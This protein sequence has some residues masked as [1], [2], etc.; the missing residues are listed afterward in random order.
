MP[1]QSDEILVE[2][3]PLTYHESTGTTLYTRCGDWFPI[4]CFLISL[5]L[6]VHRYRGGFPRN[7]IDTQ[8]SRKVSQVKV[9]PQKQSKLSPGG[10]QLGR[11]P[12]R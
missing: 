6:I 10:L 1:T 3:A 5:V 11:S 12:K 7:S 4:L 9:H 2:E 8:L